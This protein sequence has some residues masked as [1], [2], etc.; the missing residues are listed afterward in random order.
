MADD[1]DGERRSAATVLL[2]SNEAMN[3]RPWIALALLS[4]AVAP[5]AAAPR[6]NIV[7]PTDAVLETQAGEVL[8]HTVVVRNDGTAD[9][10]IESVAPG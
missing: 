3:L 5:V 1:H 8:V 9:L 10:L 6:M 2:E 7:T 4:V